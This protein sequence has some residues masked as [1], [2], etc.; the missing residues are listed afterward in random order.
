M[1]NNLFI[2]QLF[3]H[4]KMECNFLAKSQYGFADKLG[5]PV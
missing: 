4:Y 3:L 5:N 2:L 1:L